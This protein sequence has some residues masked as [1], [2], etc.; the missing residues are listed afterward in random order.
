MPSFESRKDEAV[1]RYLE[2]KI[3]AKV[4]AMCGT[5]DMPDSKTNHCRGY[6][7]ALR[8]FLQFY[9]KDLPHQ[10]NKE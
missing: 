3:E 7:A 6:I 9:N 8:D 2:E 5:L 10:M 1:N 4:G